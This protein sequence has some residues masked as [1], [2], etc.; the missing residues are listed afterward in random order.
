MCSR[1]ASDNTMI[2]NGVAVNE[3]RVAPKMLETAMFPR[4]RWLLLILVPM[5]MHG[6]GYKRI[7]PQRKKVIPFNTQFN[8]IQ[9]NS[10]P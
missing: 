10:L 3:F 6:Q 7:S 9:R 8:P 1:E 2:R 4:Q 5:Y